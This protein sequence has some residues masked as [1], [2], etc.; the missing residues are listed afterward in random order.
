MNDIRDSKDKQRERFAKRGRFAAEQEAGRMAAGEW[1]K[2]LSSRVDQCEK[3][4]ASVEAAER[5]LAKAI[6][7]DIDALR[8]AVAGL[9]RALVAVGVL[10]PNHITTCQNLLDKELE[11]CV[12]TKERPWWKLWRR[13]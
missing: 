2:A 10:T 11:E 3:S 8:R 9:S 12:P 6:G 4:V 1:G 7:D 13:K 5:A